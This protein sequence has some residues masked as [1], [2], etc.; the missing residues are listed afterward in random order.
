MEGQAVTF[1]AVVTPRT[2][3]GLVQIFEGS[4]ILGTLTLS[5]GSASLTLSPQDY[6]FAVGTH[7]ITV[8]YNGDANYSMSTSPILTL[9]IA[10]R[11]ATSMTLTPSPNP[12]AVGQPVVFTARLSPS[13]ATGS[14][15]FVDGTTVIATAPISGGTATFTTSALTAGT[16]GVTAVYNGDVNYAASSSL[17]ITQTVKFPTATSLTSNNAT[18]LSG[19]TVQFTAAVSPVTATGSV[20][21]RDGSSPLATVTLSNGSAVLSISSLAV[22]V[23]SI[24]AVYSGDANNSGSTSP[25]SHGNRECPATRTAGSPRRNGRFIQPDQP[26]LDGEP[27]FGS[28]LQRLCEP[29]SWLH[30][31]PRQ[32]NRHGRHR[33]PATPTQDCPPPRLTITG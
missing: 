16:H 5:G 23:H 28:Y 22:G 8:N 25:R 12:S 17:T 31:F 13:A 32:S 20:Q 1:T 26:H 33:Q 30:A 18:V 2:A 6:A 9:T 3:T 14:V 19:Q 24:T 7:S 4:G 29:D 21:F 27:D 11:T 10:R 15:L